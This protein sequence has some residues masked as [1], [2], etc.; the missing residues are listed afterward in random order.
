MPLIV[1]TNDEGKLVVWDTNPDKVTG[2]WCKA[3]EVPDLCYRC[4]DPETLAHYPAEAYTEDD[5]GWRYGTCHRCGE[6][7][8]DDE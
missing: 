3:P 7:E 8:E 4:F 1:T 6:M 2:R 5:E